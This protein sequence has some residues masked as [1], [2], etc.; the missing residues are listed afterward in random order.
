MK[1]SLPGINIY[2]FYLVKIILYVLIIFSIV[3]MFGNDM[4]AVINSFRKKSVFRKENE[5][6]SNIYMHLDKIF[7]VLYGA[8]N[9]KRIYNFFMLSVAFFFVP[10]LLLRDKV[11]FTTNLLISSFLLFL[12]YIYLRL[13]LYKIRVESSFDAEKVVS[14]ISNQYKIANYNMSEAIRRS[15][16]YLASA[17]YSRRQIYSLALMLDVYRTDEELKKYLDYFVYSINTQWAKMLSNNIYFAVS[18]D[19]N[20]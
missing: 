14:E 20:V 16:R 17:P 6:R 8:N 9:E 3:L 12:P 4:I 10:F 13:N 7:Y 15:E 1:L 2:L 5:K 11:N 19:L 18:K